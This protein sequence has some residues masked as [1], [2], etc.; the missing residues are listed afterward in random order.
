[1]LLLRFFTDLLESLAQNGM[2]SS[3]NGSH[4]NGEG[5]TMRHRGPA[6]ESDVSAKQATDSSKPYTAEQQEAVRK[7]VQK[8]SWSCVL[9]ITLE[10]KVTKLLS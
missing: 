10:I 8:C 6:E 1:M 2:P 4:V 3:A 7:S 9:T 5:P